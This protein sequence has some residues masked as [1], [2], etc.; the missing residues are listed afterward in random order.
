[1]AYPTDDGPIDGAYFSRD[2][3]QEAGPD[4]ALGFPDY[5]A[6]LDF[7]DAAHGRMSAEEFARLNRD[8]F[9]QIEAGTALRYLGTV[10]AEPGDHV[11]LYL[12]VEGEYKYAPV[13]VLYDQAVD[14]R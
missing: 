8:S 11:G 3:L 1:V 12:V 5:R 7:R 13:Y 14:P 10:D 2:V 6:F 4:G 9:L